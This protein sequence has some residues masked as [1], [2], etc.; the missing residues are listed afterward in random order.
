MKI[1]QNYT[2]KITSIEPK[3]QETQHFDV[4]WNIVDY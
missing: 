1:N 2:N 3:I 4:V